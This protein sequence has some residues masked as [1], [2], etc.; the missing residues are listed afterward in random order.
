MW[1]LRLQNQPIEYFSWSEIRSYFIPHG[2]FLPSRIYSQQL[3]HETLLARLNHPR[4]VHSLCHIA[5]VL[6]KGEKSFWDAARVCVTRFLMSWCC[7]VLVCSTSSQKGSPLTLFHQMESSSALTRRFTH[8]LND[9]RNPWRECERGSSP[10]YWRT[11]G[12]LLKKTVCIFHM[13]CYWLDEG[14]ITV[15]QWIGFSWVWILRLYCSQNA[16]TVAG[17]HTLLLLSATSTWW[18][19]SGRKRL[20]C[21]LC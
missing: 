3:R 15:V 5:I 16:Y 19:E 13:F 14:S 7:W 2:P 6:A 21:G 9:C 1:P 10:I 4:T 18:M 11:Y 17:M 20:K 12:P 8:W